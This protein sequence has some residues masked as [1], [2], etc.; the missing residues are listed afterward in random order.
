M[1]ILYDYL[2]CWGW[3]IVTFL[4]VYDDWVH[5]IVCG[6]P[7]ENVSEINSNCSLYALYIHMGELFSAC[8]F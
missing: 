7:Y 1:F 2:H 3:N 6:N 8:K 4:E 5:H